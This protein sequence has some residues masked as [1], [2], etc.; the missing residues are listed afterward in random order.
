MRYDLRTHSL[1]PYLP[2]FSAHG[3]SFSRD[4][5][6]MAYVSHPQGILWQS[7]T[8]GSDRHQLTFPPMAA[9]LP[10]WSPDGSQIAFSGGQPGKP[11]QIFLIHAW[12]R[13]S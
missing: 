9:W 10:R 13:R 8:D 7:R 5:Q 1:A 4:G 12:G 11:R 3:L 6:R 2:G